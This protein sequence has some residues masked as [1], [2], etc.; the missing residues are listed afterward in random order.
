MSGD[1]Y[2]PD[3]RASEAKRAALAGSHRYLMPNRVETFAQLGIS[4]VIGRREGYRFWD[5]DGRELLDFHLNGGTFNLGHRN[6]QLVAA[7]VD[8]L[9]RYDIGNHHFPSAPR[10]ALAAELAARSP[11]GALQHVVLTPSGSEAIDVAVRAARRATGRRK[12][13]AYD[14]AFHGRSALA[15]ALGDARGA[16]AFH[17]D[18]PDELLTV[19]YSNLDAAA[20]ALAR[21]DVAA[22]VAEVIPA[23]AGFPL[24]PDGYYAALRELCDRHGTL[25]VADEVQTGLGRT[26]DVWAIDGFGAVPDVLVT[27]KGLSGGLYPIA[28]V[29]LNDATAAWL[30]DDGWGYVSTFGGSELGCVVAREA[31]EMSTTPA[32]L[33]NARTMGEWFR[34]RLELLREKHPFLVEIRQR[35]LVMG[36]RF[37]DP[38]GALAM[39]AAL[40]DEGVWAMFAGFD[41][42]VLQ[43]KP[44]LLVDEEYAH[45]ALE[46]FERAIRRVEED[47]AGR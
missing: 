6:P 45:E 40:F 15:G 1:G 9:D 37:D 27:G 43:W 39:A 32:T 10:A 16:R 22:V 30:H 7:L 46:R 11:G 29:L 33:A 47:R 26:G 5:V 41:P 4:L 2:E 25:L 12:V 24:P 44:G 31:L 23:T 3:P 17:S 21:D 18:Q 8:A 14:C 28:A 13:V 19:P 42:S 36:L 20:A 38:Q 35:G 34:E